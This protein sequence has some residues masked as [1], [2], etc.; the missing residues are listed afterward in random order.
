MANLTTLLDQHA[1]ERGTYFVTLSFVDEN[2]AA[3]VPDSVTWTLTNDRGSIIN[4]RSAVVIAVPATSNTIVLSA[5]DL[6]IGDYGIERHLLVEGIYDST[7]GNNLPF[8][9]QANFLIENFTAVI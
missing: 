2:G 3:V 8:K 9:S 5:A 4:S 7:L 6:A 1:P